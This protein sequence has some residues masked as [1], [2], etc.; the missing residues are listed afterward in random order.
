MVLIEWERI[1]PYNV[2]GVPLGYH[3]TTEYL[4]DYKS[5]TVGPEKESYFASNLLPSTSYVFKIC[6]FNK[7]GL[8][9]C[10]RTSNTTLDSRKLPIY[11]HVLY[12]TYAFILTYFNFSYSVDVGYMLQG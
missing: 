6:A 2:N 3:I 8:G 9:P 11:M 1:A 10:E 12:S 5:T 7:V 4:S